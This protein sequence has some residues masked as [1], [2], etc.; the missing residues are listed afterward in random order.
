M[1]YTIQIH[2]RATE[3]VMSWTIIVT[4]I[5][6]V[7][8]SPVTFIYSIPHGEVSQRCEELVFTV[9][10]VSNIGQSEP[11]VV[12]GGFPIGNIHHCTHYSCLTVSNIS[13]NVDM[14][15]FVEL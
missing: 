1:N 3:D 9:Y 4:S 11:G 5:S 12:N 8:M 13:E 14:T 15:T 6:V 7:A 2:N 10:A